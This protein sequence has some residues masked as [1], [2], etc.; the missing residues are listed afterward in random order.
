MSMRKFGVQ[1]A[2]MAGNYRQ[3]WS[4]AIKSFRSKWRP[5]R[6]ALCL[7]PLSA[8]VEVPWL[9]VEAPVEV[10]EMELAEHQAP[11]PR[12]AELQVSQRVQD[13]REFLDVGASLELAASPDFLSAQAFGRPMSLR[14]AAALALENG[15]DVRIAAEQSIGQSALAAATVRSLGPQVVL[16]GSVTRE[17]ETTLRPAGELNTD[18]E[19][20]LR[21]VQPLVRPEGQ[22]TAA[23]ELNEAETSELT[24]EN[25]R[26]LAILE[27][28]NSYLSV[29]QSQ[30]VIQFAEEHE[31]RLE[32]L[33]VIMEERVKAGGASP[34]ELQRVLARIQGIRATISDVRAGL[35]SSVA[36]LV[37]RTNSRP[38]SVT[39]PQ[40]I[41]GYLPE[42]IEGAFELAKRNNWEIRTSHNLIETAE[43]AFRTVRARR[44][45][46]VDLA[47]SRD[48]GRSRLEDDGFTRETN[49]G[50]SMNWTL[51]RNGAL[52][53]ELRSAAARVRE[54]EI[55]LEEAENNLLR[56]LRETY[57]VLRAISEQYTAYVAQ[58][59]SNEAVVDAFTAQIVSTNRPVLDV[60]EAYQSLFQS[61]VDLTNVVITETQL[62]LRVLYLMGELTLDSLGASPP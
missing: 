46:T 40:Q 47:L 15:T 60:L 18:G 39:L 61:K 59:R 6:L 41:D 29:L 62:N 50:I 3:A 14:D 49:L 11:E 38:D 24:L 33:R 5:L 37:L 56:T 45:P 4:L 1:K 22:A 35:S 55:A 23:L 42:T 10:V 20:S 21:L 8:C 57:V 43:L 28:S 13:L 25:A 17:L 32:G 16:N 58:V 54:T 51:Y 52:D 48:L 26:S 27:A 12:R 53:E 7:A 44:S 34:A 30:L 19:L 9:P 2:P 36:E 31:Q